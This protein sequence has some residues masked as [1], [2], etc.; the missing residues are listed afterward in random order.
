MFEDGLSPGEPPVSLGRFERNGTHGFYGRSVLKIAA[1]PGAASAVRISLP[2]MV[3]E[4]LTIAFCN[5]LKQTRC[6]ATPC[7]KAGVTGCSTCN[8]NKTI[9]CA[10]LCMAIPQDK[11]QP[12]VAAHCNAKLCADKRSTQMCSGVARM[13]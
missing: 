10:K 7:S 8:V 11:G 1:P 3:P 4:G 6:M 5:A 2:G 9:K 13:Y 12:D